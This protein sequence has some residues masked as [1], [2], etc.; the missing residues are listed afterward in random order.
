MWQ[1]EQRERYFESVLT[2]PGYGLGPAQLAEIKAAGGSYEQAVKALNAEWRKCVG[3]GRGSGHSSMARIDALMRK[4]H[5]GGLIPFW[6]QQPHKP[7]ATAHK[8]RWYA[9]HRQK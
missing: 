3:L 8:Q 1:A 7:K 9:R 4:A 6:H 2:G 5:A